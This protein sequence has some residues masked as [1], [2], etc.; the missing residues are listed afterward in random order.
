MQGQISRNP[1]YTAKSR[2]AIF[3]KSIP[4][5]Y[6]SVIPLPAGLSSQSV[7]CSPKIEI[8]LSKCCNFFDFKK[9]YS[10]YLIIVCNSVTELLKGVPVAPTTPLP[11]V[12]S[13]KYRHLRYKSSAFCDALFEIPDML[14]SFVGVNNVCH[15][16][17]NSAG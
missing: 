11:P 5:P 1:Q 4:S 9:S 12:F 13:S 10:R 2:M 14:V 7:H 16:C 3:L 17:E 6:R 8:Q 15:P